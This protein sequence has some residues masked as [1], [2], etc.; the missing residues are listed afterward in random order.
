MRQEISNKN[1]TNV[2]IMSLII[3]LVCLLMSLVKKIIK[4]KK[5]DAF[6]SIM[7]RNAGFTCSH[8]KPAR[9]Q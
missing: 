3:L 4:K 6:D 9:K 8:M 2:L 7:N 5:Y 1:E